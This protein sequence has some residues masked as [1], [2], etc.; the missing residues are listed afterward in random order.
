MAFSSSELLPLSRPPSSSLL[1]S[2]PYLNFLSG[3]TFFFYYL[4]FPPNTAF[5]FCVYLYGFGGLV[6]LFAS[7]KMFA[8]ESYTMLK[9]L[10]S[11]CLLF[12]ISI[13]VSSSSASYIY[14]LFW[15][16]STQTQTISITRIT[17]TTARMIINDFED[18]PGFSCYE[19]L[20]KV[21]P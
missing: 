1:S 11:Y 16:Y 20:A 18:R 2:D 3:L 12:L 10:S 8:F 6:L 21:T 14:F 5:S 13:S 15:Y 19:S 17:P 9:L 4:V 7:V